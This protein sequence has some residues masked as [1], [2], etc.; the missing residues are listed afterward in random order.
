MSI[1]EQL[2]DHS[3]TDL[4]IAVP[5]SEAVG[6][7]HEFVNALS[8]N[9][10]IE[11]IR[12]TDDFMGDLRHDDRHKLLSAMGQIPTLK[13]V[14]LADGLLMISDI[15]IMISRAKNL[16]GLTL[17]NLILQGIEDHF[18]AAE[19]ALYQHPSLKE[20]EMNDCSPAWKEASLDK[21]I[22]AGQKFS[23]TSISGEPSP[24]AQTAKSA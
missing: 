5:A 1:L 18:I 7:L 14:F 8:E 23:S 12:L 13:V 22:Q 4:A 2:K 19:A 16:R 20:F 10:S 21:L 9:K 17:R 3:I 6:D 24:N 11:T 15:T